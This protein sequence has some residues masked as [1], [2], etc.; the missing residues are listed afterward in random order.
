LHKTLSERAAWE[1]CEVCFWEDDGQDEA[2]IDK[3]RGGPNGSLS[4]RE[5]R[6]NYLRFGACEAS[7]IKNVRAPHPD[8]YPD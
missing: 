5:A 4:L 7:M 8:E 2:D 6:T 1:I 3:C